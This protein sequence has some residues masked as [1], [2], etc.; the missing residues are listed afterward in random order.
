MRFAGRWLTTMAAMVALVAPF[1]GVHPALGAPAGRTIT[2]QTVAPGVVHKK[3]VIASWPIRIHVLEIDPSTDARVD[4]GLPGGP[5]GTRAKTSE[6]ASR[7]SAVAAVNGGF[8]EKWGRPSGVFAEDGKLATTP[9]FAETLFAASADEKSFK[10]GRFP[11]SIKASNPAAGSLPLTIQKWNATDVPTGEIGGYTPAAKADAPVPKDTCS[12]RLTPPRSKG[13][14]P[15]G[16]GVTRVH[17]VA[18][19]K[20]GWLPLEANNRTVL[21]AKRGTAAASSLRAYSVGDRVSVTW[22]LGL[23]HILD[24]IGGSPR[25]V[26]GGQ[27]VAKMCDDYVCHTHPRTG[28]GITKTGEILFVTVDGRQPGYSVGMNIVQFGYEMKRQGAVD[29]VN[30]DGGGSTTMVIHG[31]VV[32]RPSGGEQRRV[33]NAMLILKG[34]DPGESSFPM[35]FSF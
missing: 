5:L 24:A 22:S 34:S 23:P 9:L 12:V 33:G 8:V 3:I 10:I 16:Y 7:Y 1:V 32:N 21:A 2:T 14:G 11:L 17:K 4:V 15:N 27:M 19:V 6:I 20:C 35:G 31:R 26:A 29:A 28:I 25:L 13:W 18:A 30:I